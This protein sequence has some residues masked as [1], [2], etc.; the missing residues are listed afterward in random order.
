MRMVPSK[1]S[2]HDFWEAMRGTKL[3]EGHPVLTHPCEAAPAARRGTF[4]DWAV[5]LSLHVDGVPVTGVG[6]AWSKTLD[7]YSW[8]SLLAKGITVHF[9]FWIWSVFIGL[10]SNGVYNTKN[11]FWKILS[12]SFYWFYRGLWPDRD[13]R[14]VPYTSGIDFVRRLKPLADGYFGVLWVVKSDLEAL[15]KEF[16]LPNYNSN[17]LC[18]WCPCHTHTMNPFEFREEH[19]EWRRNVITKTQWAMSPYRFHSIFSIPGVA[20]LTFFPDFMHC[21]HLGCD[22]YALASI[23][24]IIVYQILNYGSPN[25]NMTYLFEKIKTIYARD[26]TPTQFSN[27][28][29]S[30][31]TSEREPGVRMPKLSGRAAEVRYLNFPLR[32]IWRELMDRRNMQHVQIECLL[33]LSCQMEDLLNHYDSSVR[34]PAVKANEFLQTCMKYLIC[35]NALGYF[36]SEV[37]QPRQMLFDMVPKC[38]MLAHCGLKALEINPRLCWCY[39]GEDFMHTCKRVTSRC[40]VGNKGAQATKK[41]C[42]MYRMGLHLMLADNDHAYVPVPWRKKLWVQLWVW[43]R[44][45]KSFSQKHVSF[46]FLINIQNINIL[47]L[48][49]NKAKM[50][51][52]WVA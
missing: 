36:Y 13:W 4:R 34:F 1:E 26:N 30:M 11:T 23:L 29:V 16:G 47:N 5:P 17:D 44:P 37:A 8:C 3:L 12:W 14:G 22:M 43:E 21:K 33:N 45:L 18:S 46:K 7:V 10:I 50:M 32:E 40:V 27:I 52:L 42:Q 2:L 20:I 38:H 28:T 31:F 39:A 41:F 48:W 25:A 49:E 15:T 6:K 19:S 9:N 35:Y 51:C 24:Y